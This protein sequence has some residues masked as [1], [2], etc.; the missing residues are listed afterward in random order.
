M[1][2]A[3]SV[4]PLAAG[5]LNT[6]VTVIGAVVGV[7]GALA[8][9]LGLRSSVGLFAG[10]GILAGVVLLSYILANFGVMRG[11]GEFMRGFLIGINT[12]ANL[13]LGMAAF[14]GMFGSTLG[15]LFAIAIAVLNFLAAI[16]AVSTS[17]VYQGFL[18]W[19]NF[20][21]PMA[22]L[23][24]GVGFVL[25]I[26]NLLGGLIGLAGVKLFRIAGFH[27]DWRTGTFFT[28]G[29]FVSNLNYIGAGSAFNMG[30]F[31]FTYDKPPVRAADYV[32]DHEAGHTLNLGA[33]GWVFHYIGALDENVVPKRGH[34]ALSERLADS[35]AA[36]TDPR[37]IPMWA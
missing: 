3:S 26:L 8:L 28:R 22:W 19:L 1:T 34:D 16:E 14:G 4:T 33:F 12:G 15:V 13:A 17:E 20:V 18:G 5:K 6:T 32:S 29:G 23:V 9:T 10:L 35:N 36:P 25:F 30:N 31:A 21:N 2:Y 37:N 27:A 7:G 11:F 24:T